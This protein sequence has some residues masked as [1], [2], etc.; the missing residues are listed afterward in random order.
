[1]GNRRLLALALGAGIVVGGAGCG[2]AC[3]TLADRVCDCLSGGQ[4]QSDCK[5]NV[6]ARIGASGA[7]AAEQSNC[8]ALLATCPVPNGDVNVCS[9]ISNTCAGRVACGLALPLPGGGDG[10]TNV[11]PTLL[12]STPEAP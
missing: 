9:W 10:C 2:S 3:E 4:I 8:Q 6:Q 7:T 11:T 5:K 1:M 12:E